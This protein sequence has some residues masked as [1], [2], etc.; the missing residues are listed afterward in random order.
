ML[1]LHQIEKERGIRS[2]EA[3]RHGQ[4]HR[5]PSRKVELRT[6]RFVPLFYRM[7]TALATFTVKGFLG[8]LLLNEDYETGYQTVTD[9]PVVKGCL[10]A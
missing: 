3:K 5:L 10:V 4:V 6:Q 8:I 9:R 7:P 1:L 2:K